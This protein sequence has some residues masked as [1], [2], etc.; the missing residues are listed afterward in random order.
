M[1]LLQRTAQWL[2]SKA[3]VSAPVS[4]QS[5]PYLFL[6]Q[7]GADLSARQAWDLYKSVDTFAK[8]VDLISDQVALLKPVV[9]VGGELVDDHPLAVALERPGW[10][11]TRRRLI[12]EMAVQRLV[13]GTAYLHA[14]GNVRMAPTAFDVFM[15]SHVNN[16]EG[17]DGWADLVQVNEGRR[18]FNFNRIDQRADIRWL[19]GNLGEIIPVYDMAGDQK[20]VGLSR[21][22]SVKADVELKLKGLRHNNSLIDNGA[23]LSGVLSFKN[24]LQRE[25]KAQVDTDMRSLVSGAGNAGRVL[26][27]TGGEMDFKP[28]S[29]SPRDLDWQ[30]L[31]KVVDEAIVAR[32]NVPV[33]LFS[34][35]AQTHNNYATAW[36][37]LYDLAVLPEFDIIYSAIGRMYSDRTGEQVEI[38]HDELTSSILAQKAVERATELLGAQMVTINEARDI[39]GYEPLAGGDEISAPLGLEPQYE[40]LF[41]NDGTPLNAPPTKSPKPKDQARATLN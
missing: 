37:L 30:N 32:Y 11:R 33:T 1:N 3:A 31:V 24:P 34:T 12:K 35:D 4:P 16:I 38:V 27:T 23:K 8:V 19:D 40:D 7:Q 25:Q 10:N 13:T 26:V 22:Q 14:T 28:I 36:H 41:D 21:I 5:V 18:S 6:A 39:V 2:A 29:M 15:T 20:G 9:K 17:R